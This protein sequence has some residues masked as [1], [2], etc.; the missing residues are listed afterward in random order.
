MFRLYIRLGRYDRPI[1][2]WLLMLPCWWGLALA[3]PNHFPPPLFLGLFALGAAVMRGAG[4]TLNDLIDR[5]LD[6]RVERTKNRPLAS[7]QLSP[8]QALV[9]FCLQSLVGLSILLSLPYACWGIG[10][11][12]LA[13]LI[14]YPFMKRLIDWPQAV[15]GLAFNIGIFMGAAAVSDMAYLDWK[16]LILLYCA[17]ICWTIFYD[18]IYALQD[19]KDD[20]KVGIKS[21]AILF[22]E[23]LMSALWIICA[24]ILV[25]LILTKSLSFICLVVLFLLMGWILLTLNPTSP[26][27]CLQRFKANQWVG[28]I[29]FFGLATYK[30]F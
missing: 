1:G 6:V 7:G 15:L 20:L 28:W 10:I 9:F 19:I 8:R 21:T 2:I 24:F 17:G 30:F 14:L 16:S 4:C 3:T 23:N 12:G 27:N 13:L 26:E 11:I 22:G 5:N 25:F 29:V 18:T